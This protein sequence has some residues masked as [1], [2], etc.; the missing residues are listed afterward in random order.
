[1]QTASHGWSRRTLPLQWAPGAKRG[2]AMPV[3]G[4][5]AAHDHGGAA[6]ATQGQFRAAADRQR[7][8]GRHD[9]NQQGSHGGG[10]A[11][12]ERHGQRH[13]QHADEVHGPDADA[14]RH[15][16]GGEPP[17]GVTALCRGH[18]RRHSQRGIGDQHRD[19]FR[20]TDEPVIVSRNHALHGSWRNRMGL[21]SRRILNAHY[22]VLRPGRSSVPA[23]GDGLRGPANPPRYCAE[24]A[25]NRARMRSDPAA[26]RSRPPVGR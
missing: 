21:K 18:M 11:V 8:A 15:R 25:G 24:P 13:C 2:A 9:R 6:Q 4:D 10:D 3:S 5:A 16:T 22:V 17:P 14:H 7:E 12:G 23:T 19:H 1:M 20:Q 26:H